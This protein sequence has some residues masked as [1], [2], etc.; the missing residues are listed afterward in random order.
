MAVSAVQ[1]APTTVI[2]FDDLVI[3]EGR[4][5]LPDGYAG[6]NWDPEWFYW[7]WDN[8]PYNP[9]SPSTRISS[10]NYGG[11]IDFSP[12]GTP[13][14]FEGAYLS[15]Y[16]ITEVHFEGYLDGNLVGTSSALLP[17][18]TPTFLAANFGS[19]VDYVNVVSTSYDFFAL[20][21]VTFQQ[22]PA[23]GALLLGSLGLGCVSWLRRRRTL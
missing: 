3:M 1:A 9:S 12:L 22:V 11:W 19:P 6:V 18:S 7:S 5:P 16:D 2:N 8:D 13:V 20:D 21:D 17:S 15:G 4:S 10:W 23:P 14:I